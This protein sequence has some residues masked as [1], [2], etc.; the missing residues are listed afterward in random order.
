MY[1]A[2]LLAADWGFYYT[3]S[4]NLERLR[5]DLPAG[6]LSSEQTRIIEERIEGLERV[7]E[8]E[9]KTRGWKMRARIGTRKRWYQEVAEKSETF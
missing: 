4:M 1:I 2:K 6:D 9:P 7:I 3:V 8:D 5:R